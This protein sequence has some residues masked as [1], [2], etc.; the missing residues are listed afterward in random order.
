MITAEAFEGAFKRWYQPLCLFSLR[1]ITSTDDA[2][3]IVQ[4]TFTEVWAKL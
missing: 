4:Q 3:D 1:Y 2:E